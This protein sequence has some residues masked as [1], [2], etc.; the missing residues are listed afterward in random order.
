M[1]VF[2]PVTILN[3]LPPHVSFS[4]LFPNVPPYILFY[5]QF[6]FSENKKEFSFS[7]DADFA[8]ISVTR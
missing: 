3:E 6:S 5:W 1:F 2:I 4:F 7:Q 8:L